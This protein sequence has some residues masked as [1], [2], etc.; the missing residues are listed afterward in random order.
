MSPPPI[1]SALLL[2]AGLGIRLAPLTTVR[3]KPAVP[4]AGEPLVRRIAR[5]LVAQGVT[6]LVLNLHHLPE[7]IAAVVGDGADLGGRVR[8]SWEQPVVLG[9]AGGPRQALPLLDADSFFIVNGDTLTNVDL[10]ALANH[11]ATSNALVTLALAP[12]PNPR[13]YG[14]LRLDADGRVTGVVRRGPEAADAFHFLGVQIVAAEAFAWLEAGR[15]RNSIGDAYDEILARHPGSIAGLVTE[16]AFEDI[17]TVTDY[18]RT[19]L[20][21]IERAGGHGWIGRELQLASKARV[22]RSIV[23][24][25]VRIEPGA[26]L[27]E[28]IVTDRVVV[29]AGSSFQHKV[30]SIDAGGQLAVT[31][32]EVG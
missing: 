15:P 7:T 20:A 27:D 28:C 30:L 31:P 4:V 18:W 16:A 5:W 3:A 29:P 13:K 22:T 1:R 10:T 23:W 2:T 19:S 21:H 6:D 14:G 17:G 11:H 25:D 26:S 12:N 24:D 32:F 8:Y 9:T